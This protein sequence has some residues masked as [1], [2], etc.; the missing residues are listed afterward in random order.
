LALPF[1]AAHLRSLMIGLAEDGEVVMRALI[2][3]RVGVIAAASSGSVLVGDP[4]GAG[5]RRI[6]N[7]LVRS[8]YPVQVLDAADD[9]GGGGRWS[10]RWACCATSCR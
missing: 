6:G 8:G 1:D 10:G 4:Q 5:L 2:L 9:G 7:F 3:R